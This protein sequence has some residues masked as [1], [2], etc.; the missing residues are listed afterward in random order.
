MSIE[1]VKH[2]KFSV[3]VEDFIRFLE[4]KTFESECPACHT[5]NWTV[6]GSGENEMTYRLI[7]PMRDG[8]RPNFVNFLGIY[9]NECGFV[10]QHLAKVVRRWVDDNPEPEQLELDEMATDDNE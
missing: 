5:A 7:T 9:C 4:A 2:H 3:T 10:R 6:I 1:D 8:P